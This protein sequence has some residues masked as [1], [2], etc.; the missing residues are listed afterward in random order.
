MRVSA[1]RMRAVVS[2]RGNKRDVR[3][4]RHAGGYSVRTLLSL[5]LRASRHVQDHLDLGSRDAFVSARAR[6][7][8]ML[9]MLLLAL[10]RREFS[11]GATRPLICRTERE[12]ESRRRRASARESLNFTLSK[13]IRAVKYTNTHSRGLARAF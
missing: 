11:A 5:S 8:K 10:Y 3:A 9:R 6:A 1:A 13:R 7:R 2:P 4:T 12:K